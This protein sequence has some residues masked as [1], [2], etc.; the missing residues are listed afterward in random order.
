MF[1]FRVV[2]LVLSDTCVVVD[3]W[4]TQETQRV[5]KIELCLCM[6]NALFL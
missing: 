1:L 2:A 6:E 4:V 3:S 5:V